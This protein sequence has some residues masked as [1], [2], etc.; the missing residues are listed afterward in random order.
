MSIRF[1]EKVSAAADIVNLPNAAGIGVLNG[2]PLMRTASGLIPI[3]AV[4]PTG[5]LDYYVDLNVSASGDG[6]SPATAFGTIAEAI[7]ASNISI[8]LTANRWWARRN[9]IFVMGDGITESLTVLPE[10]CD[11]I[12]M[13]SDLYPFPRVIGVQTI[14]AAAVGCR[15]INM[16]FISTGAGATMTIPAG[17]HGFQLLG[18]LFLPTVTGSTIGLSITDTAACKIIGN[19]FQ[20][21]AGDPATGVYATCISVL[22][23]VGHEMEIAEN[24]MWGTAGILIAATV[25]GFGSILRENIIRA[26][27]LPINDDSDDFMIVNNRWITDINTGTSTAGWDFNL[28]LAVGNIQMGVTGLCDTVPYTKIAE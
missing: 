17:C 7:A 11:I 14:A 10:K 6:L 26:I 24:K 8:G 20:P 23:T 3:G 4:N 13:G 16:G 5:A 21:A 18:C 28:A 27:D 1:I 15:I 25:A 2:Q 12:G 19:T 9:R 22:G